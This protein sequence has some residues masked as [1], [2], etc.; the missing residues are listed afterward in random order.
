MGGTLVP[1]AQGKQEREWGRAGAGSVSCTR[2]AVLALPLFLAAET[3]TALPGGASAGLAA[4]RR[5]QSPAAVPDPPG[6]QPVPSP[7]QGPLLLRHPQSRRDPSR[8]PQ[9]AWSTGSPEV[10][11]DL[12]PL[13]P[14]HGDQHPAPSPFPPPGPARAGFHQA[15]AGPSPS[16]AQDPAGSALTPVLPQSMGRARERP[17]PETGR[18]TE[19]HGQCGEGSECSHRTGV[20]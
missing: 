14:A 12:P 2:R 1:A 10:P 5:G 13:C 20:S 3:A 8:W 6:T 16:T 4:A 11:R 15:Q 9:H 19:L 7:S 18:G 17:R